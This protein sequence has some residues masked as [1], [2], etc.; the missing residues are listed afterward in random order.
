MFNEIIPKKKQII[1]SHCDDLLAI[2]VIFF[3]HVIG[4]AVIYIDE[5]DVMGQKKMLMNPSDESCNHSLI[6]HVCSSLVLLK[7]FCAISLFRRFN[8]RKFCLNEKKNPFKNEICPNV[9]S[10]HVC[11]GARRQQCEY[12]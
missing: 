6:I 5:H 7:K 3:L 11:W 1:S 9:T 10:F 2:I 8:I 12:Y 4:L